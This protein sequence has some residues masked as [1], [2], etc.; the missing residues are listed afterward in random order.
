V[1]AEIIDTNSYE[2]GHDEFGIEY[3]IEGED[4]NGEPFEAQVLLGYVY[5]EEDGGY[6]LSCAV[7]WNGAMD[8][9]D[10]GEV[11][12]DE[13]SMDSGQFSPRVRREADKMLR[14]LI[15]EFPELEDVAEFLE[16]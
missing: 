2:V 7:V 11:L 5:S 16:W 14:K 3:R 13:E 8:Y 9:T 15:K 6:Y 10:G 12:I 4:Q 1:Y